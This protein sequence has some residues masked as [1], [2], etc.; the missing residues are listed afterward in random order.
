MIVSQQGWT[1]NEIYLKDLIANAPPITVVSGKNFLYSADVFNGRMYIVTNEDTPHYKVFAAPA[2]TPDASH[3]KLLIPE[4]N[5]A[6]LQELDI[7]GGKLVANYEKN[8]SSLIKV[9]SV[10]GKPLSEV[11]L[12]GIGSVVGIG[13]QW[14]SK[15]AFLGFQS[16]T[17]PPTVLH[18]DMQSGATSVFTRVDAP[19]DS[20]GYEVKQI[21]YK[22]KDGTRVPMFV[23]S[24]KGLALDGKN[25]TLLFGYGG[26]QV[27]ETPVFSRGVF[28]W[29]ENG[30]V[31]ALANLRGG[32]EFGEGWHR[33]GMLEKKQNVF[34]DF[35]AA[36]EHLI[37]QKYTDREHLAIMGGSNGGLLVGAAVTQHP[38]LFRA[39]VCR[40]PLLDMLRYQNFLIAKLWIPEYGSAADPKQFDYLYAY[41]PYH[42][43]KP[44]TLYPAILFMTA[45]SDTRVDPDAR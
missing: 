10:E 2:A 35:A 13:G 36:A 38:D 3:W 29:L 21:W 20:S 33:A 14:D 7:I 40:V 9:F 5:D 22:S 27:S 12:P 44:G 37:T 6:V 42:H 8:V 26:F 30:G 25:P 23:V 15:E 39:A 17:V 45:D 16:F 43:V 11:P 31:Y 18:Y 4:S 34:D 41:S 32:S 19:I 1:K 28:L 24:K